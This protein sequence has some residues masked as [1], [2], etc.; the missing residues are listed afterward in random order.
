ML[1]ERAS[2][3]RNWCLRVSPRTGAGAAAEVRE[4]FLGELRKC[5]G[6]TLAARLWKH[7]EGFTVALEEPW[8]TRTGKV[9]PL[10][11]LGMEARKAHAS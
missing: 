9:L 5:Y 11:V 6:G 10:H 8:A 2:G 7:S 3:R 4:F 1:N